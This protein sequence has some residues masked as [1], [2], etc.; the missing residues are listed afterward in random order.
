[1]A[2]TRYANFILTV[3]ALAL[4][5]IAIENLVH[6]SR[7]AQSSSIQPVAICDVVGH[8][9]L[10]VERDMRGSFIKVQPRTN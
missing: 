5:A 1:M 2:N 4:T 8:D 3:I 9:C 7:A 6:P 10:D